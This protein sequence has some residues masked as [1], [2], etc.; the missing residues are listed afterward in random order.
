MLADAVPLGEDDD[1]AALRRLVGQ[2]GHLRRLGQLRG[3]HPR[4]RH[5]LGRLAVAERDRAGLVEQQHVA[6]ARGLD[7]AAGEGEH[8]A[9]DQAVHA[10]DP[11]RREQRP[12]RGRDQ[13]DQQRDQRRLRELGVGEERERAQRD[14]HDDEDQGQRDQQDAERDLVRRLAPL[15]ALDQRDH[16]VEERL[17]R[18][19]GDLDHDPVREHPGA[20]GDRRAV[21]AG[22][23]DHRCRLAGDRRL[24]DRGDA[25]D[26]RP[27]AG[28]RLARLDDDEIAAEQLGGGL[29]AAVA[30]AR[31]RLGA[32][33][34]QAPCLGAAATLGDR[35]GEVGEDDRQPEPDRDREGEPGGLVAAAE[36]LAAEDRDQPAG[37]GDHGADLDHEHHRVAD[38]DAGVELAQRLDSAGRRISGSNR[39]RGWASALIRSAP[40]RRARG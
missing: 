22:L 39:E 12:D 4:H 18:F 5:E 21:A 11:D 13:R 6:V 33:R 23:A 2:R 15:R 28:N 35:L 26:H 10:G 9:A 34:P 14:D 25:L 31:G 36:R 3:V 40:L 27:V 37:A 38:L 1:R 16:P 19:L 8:V 30:Q 7:R 32:H 17:A 20:A 29:L 24:V